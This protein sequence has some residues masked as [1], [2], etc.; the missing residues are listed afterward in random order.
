MGVPG[1]EINEVSESVV[2]GA[3]GVVHR[4][5][6]VEPPRDSAPYRKVH[7]IDFMAFTSLVGAR[8]HS[9]FTPTHLS[10]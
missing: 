5:A 2:P 9:F 6:T 1:I 4:V 10:L 8:A 7:D 3:L